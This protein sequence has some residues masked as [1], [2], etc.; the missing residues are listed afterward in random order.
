MDKIKVY[1]FHNGSGGGVLSVIR[2]LLQFS[3]N[4]SVENHVIY[5][6]NKDVVKQYPVNGLKGAAS[7]QV[8]Y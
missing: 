1:H 6:I 8:F 7:E 5:T 3:A 2:N 4:A